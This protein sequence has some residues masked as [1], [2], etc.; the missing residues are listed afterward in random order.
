MTKNKI[1]IRFDQ[2]EKFLEF[3]GLDNAD[4]IMYKYNG[5]PF[6]GIIEHYWDNGKLSGITEYTDGHIGG[7]QQMY[8]ENGNLEEEYTQYYGRLTGYYRRWD[9]EGNLELE[10]LWDD[11]KRIS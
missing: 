5:Q 9:E 6:T 3:D 11:G 2:I 4:D 1:K 8:F 10:S 7:L